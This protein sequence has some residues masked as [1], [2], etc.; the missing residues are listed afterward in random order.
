MTLCDLHQALTWTLAIP[1][2]SSYYPAT[3]IHSFIPCLWSPSYVPG[4]V[5]ALGRRECFTEVTFHHSLL[6]SSPWSSHSPQP[7]PRLISHHFAPRHPGSGHS[8]CSHSSGPRHMLFPLPRT[9]FQFH[10]NLPSLLQ[11]PCFRRASLTI[12]C[13]RLVTSSSLC[14]SI[15]QLSHRLSPWASVLNV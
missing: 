14:F 1:S 9:L 13:P 5:R 3:I 2:L 12:P 11:C 4:A 6:R 10:A 8:V 15:V 7:T